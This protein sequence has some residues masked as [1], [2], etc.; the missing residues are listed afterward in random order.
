VFLFNDLD[1]L[2][3]EGNHAERVDTVKEDLLCIPTE[4][5]P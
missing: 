1:A 3:I 5:T 4:T 2:P